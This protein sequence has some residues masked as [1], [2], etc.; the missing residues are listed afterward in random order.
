MGVIGQQFKSQ[1]IYLPEVLIASR[2]MHAGMDVLE[3]ALG[4]V[5]NKPVDTVQRHLHDIGKESGHHDVEGGRL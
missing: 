5:A 2:A 1:E 3:S 4:K